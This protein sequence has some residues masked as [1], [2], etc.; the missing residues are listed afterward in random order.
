L[1][2]TPY[3]VCIFRWIVKFSIGIFELN[4]ESS[5]FSKPVIGTVIFVWMVHIVTK[6]SQY[7]KELVTFL[8]VAVK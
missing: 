8:S 7:V 6:K 5:D 2:I 4:R 3:E 1:K